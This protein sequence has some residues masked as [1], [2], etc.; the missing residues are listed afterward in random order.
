[1]KKHFEDFNFRAGTLDRIDQANAIISE[2]QL[3]GYTLTLRQLYYQFVVRALI[4]NS[5]REY[6]KL[7]KTLSNARLAGLVDWDSIEDRTR[8]VR[9]NTHFDGVSDIL[10]TAS[11]TYR[12]DL[13][14]D[15]PYAIEV[16][17]EKEAL[18]GVI[19]SV[20]RELDVPYFACRGYVSQSEQWRA[21]QR[22]LVRWLDTEQKTIILHLGDHDPSGVDMTRD[23]R[24]RLD[25]FSDYSDCVEVKRIALNWDQIEA[26]QPPPNPAK[27][28]D[29]RSR[30]YISRYGNDSWELDALEPRIIDKL[31]R[32]YV[33][34]YRHGDKFSERLAL[35][36]EH[37]VQ[38]MDVANSFEGA[39]E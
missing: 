12:L 13:W 17:I 14:E 27:T 37:R 10:K 1:M 38:L 3:A 34:E 11:K 35:Q 9:A 29:T 33:R 32:D 5:Q 6:K 2:Y 24:D 19:D 8:N 25:M 16:W 15:Q 39:S 28:T 18:I 30:Q 21:G 26:Y 4:P 31:I 36:E 7:G 22:A 20:C 23:N